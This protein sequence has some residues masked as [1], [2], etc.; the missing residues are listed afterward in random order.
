MAKERDVLSGMAKAGSNLAEG[1]T[2]GKNNWVTS[3]SEL[4]SSITN[5]FRS[6]DSSCDLKELKRLQ[7]EQSKGS[8]G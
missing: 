6:E 8:R 7:R 4:Y 5:A 2:L 3:I 1:P